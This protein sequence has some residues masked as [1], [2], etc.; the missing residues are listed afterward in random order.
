ML[1]LLLIFLSISFGVTLGLGLLLEKIRIPWIFGAL[2]LGMFL[3]WKNPFVMI[4]NSQTFQWLGQ[5]GMY[6]LLFIIGFEIDI[7]EWLKQGKFITKLTFTIIPFEALFGSMFFH[8]AFGVN[9]LVSSIAALSFATVGEAMLVPILDE[10]NLVN[11][12][13]GQTIIGVGTLD[14]IFEVV[15]L[16]LVSFL[17]VG[18]GKMDLLNSAYGLIGI[19][20]LFVGMILLKRIISEKKKILKVPKVGAILIFIISIMFLFAGVGSIGDSAALG[21]L[22]AGIGIKNFIP[23]KRLKFIE[24]EIKGISYGFF[25]PIFFLWVGI[26]TDM[27]YILSS[28]ILLV[29]AAVAVSKSSKLLGT[30]LMAHKEMGTRQALMTGVALCVRF[31]TSIVVAKILLDHG[32]IPITMYSVIVTSTVLFKFIVPGLLSYMISRWKKYIT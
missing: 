1:D 5:I 31:S 10:F 29:L 23:K 13:L 25:A 30:W 9:W 22:F 15:T 32:I 16:I 26:S 20:I 21:A 19:S 24:R 8:F 28:A 3:A 11:K 6:F 7:K 17:Y 18:N 4:T 12:K 2:I 14:D 27:N